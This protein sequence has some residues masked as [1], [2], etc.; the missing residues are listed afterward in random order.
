MT[1]GEAGNNERLAFVF[2]TSRV[3]LAGLGLRTGRGGQ[4][5]RHL[6][7]D[8]ARTVRPHP[9]RGELRPGLDPVHAGH[10]A[11][12]LGSGSGRPGARADRDRPVAGAVGQTR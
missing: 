2:D 8:G 10:A 1:Q 5:R 11:H 4:Q 3:H 9:I 7:E 12:R 6:G